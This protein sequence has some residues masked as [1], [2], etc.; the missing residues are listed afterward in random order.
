MYQQRGQNSPQ[1]GEFSQR[2]CLLFKYK[3][4]W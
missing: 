3:N 2:N 1:D 4:K